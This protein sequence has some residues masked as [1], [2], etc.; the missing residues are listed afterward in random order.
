MTDKKVAVGIGLTALGGF[1]AWKFW[2]GKPPEEEEPPPVVG[3]ATLRGY[4]YDRS[5]S[6]PIPGIQALL[7]GLSVNTA[8]DGR[9][10]L[11]SIAATSYQLVFS[12]PLGRYST[13]NYGV[14]NLIP[15]EVKTIDVFLDLLPGVGTGLLWGYVTDRDT[16]GVVTGQSIRLYRGDVKVTFGRTDVAGRYAI[17]SIPEG[18]YMLFTESNIYEPYSETITISRGSQRKDLVLTPKAAQQ[19][20]LLLEFRDSAK[21]RIGVIITGTLWNY[22]AITITNAK[23]GIECSVPVTI[24]KGEWDDNM[25]AWYYI[26]GTSQENLGTLISGE[27]RQ[28]SYRITPTDYICHRWEGGYCIK[29]EFEDFSITLRAWGDNAPEVSKTIRA[30]MLYLGE[31]TL[32]GFDVSVDGLTVRAS[33]DAHLS[34]DYLRCRPICLLINGVLMHMAD[35]NI[36]LFQNGE[37]SRGYTVCLPDDGRRDVHLDY[38]YDLPAPGTYEIGIGE[39]VKTVVVS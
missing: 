39:F 26:S 19:G 4:V 14:V 18:D 13:L 30:N 32:S 6:Q 22:G 9:Y 8:F 35:P 33:I 24:E 25:G 23:L 11:A 1:L 12:D 7:N 5:T 29:K 20:E 10:K 2:P 3:T 34:G 27:P 31:I 37:R 16:G 17:D 36:T 21:G 28:L 15:D 38:Y